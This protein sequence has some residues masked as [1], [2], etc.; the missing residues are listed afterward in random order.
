MTRHFPPDVGA[1]S[2]RLQHLADVLA[3]E[4]DVTVL[5]SQPNRYAGARK[6][7]K[8]EQV[9]DVSIRRIS[10]MQVLRSRGKVGRLLT[11][12][13]GA[14]SLSLVALR[15]RRKIDLAFSS[16]PPVFYLLPGLVMKRIG[17]RPVI[18]DVRDLWL[19]W[20]AETG[21]VRSGLVMSVLRR[22]EHAAIRSADHITLTT[23]SFRQL[24]IER[25]NISPDRATVVFNGLDDALLP[26][27]PD[28][29]SRRRPGDPLTVLYAGN[30]GP[31]Q[32]ILGIRDGLT[33]SLDRWPNL[34][35]TI[36]GDGAQHEAL[37]AIDHE[38]LNVV[39]HVDRTTLATMYRQ[40]DAFLLHLADLEV[41]R[42]TVP[43]K[44]FEY[45]A[46]QSPILCGVQG[47]AR[48]IALR[49]ADCFVFESDNADSFAAA[50]GRLC[51]MDDADNAGMPRSDRSE[52]LR[53]T[54]APLWRTVVE[55][56]P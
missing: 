9:G 51:S 23:E 28:G 46:Y 33:S 3:E 7:P 35:M 20:A 43:S 54:R 32:N 29:Q 22:L 12:L 44:V 1:L 15:H 16:I 21:L 48:E 38:R 13:L 26:E 10:S 24:L 30:L 36:V 56:V 5:A 50:M 11:E 2:Y 39:P 25:H 55:S 8:R 14:L 47:E 34:T 52:I 41:Y 27:A 53:S 42:H 45:A 17:R 18:L 40:A 19:D 37:A 31:S 49:Y 4:Y 6:A